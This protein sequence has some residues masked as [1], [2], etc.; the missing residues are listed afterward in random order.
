MLMLQLLL[1]LLLHTSLV[2]IGLVVALHVIVVVDFDVVEISG[3]SYPGRYGVN[4]DAAE[5][6]VDSEEAFQVLTA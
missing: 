1:L 5:G 6:S 3:L 4:D 2:V